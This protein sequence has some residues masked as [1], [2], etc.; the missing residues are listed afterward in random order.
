MPTVLRSHG[1]I[2]FFYSHE[3]GEPPH[4]HVD[5]GD[6]SA[7]VWLENITIA[8]NHGFKAQELSRILTL[9]REHRTMLLEK[10]HGYF[11]NSR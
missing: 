6:G 7:K 4:V 1:F 5:K 2:F 3:P 8:R 9:V 10:W 11:G